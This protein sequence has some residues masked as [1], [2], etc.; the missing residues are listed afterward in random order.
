MSGKI[1]TRS[2]RLEAPMQAVEA[3]RIALGERLVAVVLFGSQARGEAT[4]ESDW[5]L[6]VIARELPEGFF[7]RHLFLKRALPDDSRGSISILGRTPEEFERRLASIYFDIALDGHVLYDPLG[8]ASHW[9]GK[10]RKLIEQ[11][12]L[13]RERSEAGDMWKWRKQPTTPWVLEWEK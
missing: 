8:Y 12:G 2:P 5:D 1:E 10:V 13:F 11:K 6:L 4:E 3:L 9:L 7:D